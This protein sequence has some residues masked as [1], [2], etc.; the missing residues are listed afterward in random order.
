MRAGSFIRFGVVNNSS[1]GIIKKSRQRSHGLARRQF[2]YMRVM[3]RHSRIAVADNGL[4]NGE[5]RIR[6]A[7]KRYK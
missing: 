4:Y 7:A 6:L 5:W 1:L 3:T 2:R